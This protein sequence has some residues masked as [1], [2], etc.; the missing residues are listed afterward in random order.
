MSIPCPIFLPMGRQQPPPYENPD[1][2]VRILTLSGSGQSQT[3][4]GVNLS[5]PSDTGGKGFSWIKSRNIVGNHYFTPNYTTNNVGSINTPGALIVN[6]SG[7]KV[8]HVVNQ[9]SGANGGTTVLN[10]PNNGLAN[11]DY[12]MYT[13]R[14]DR[15]TNWFSTYHYQGLTAAF[16]MNPLLNAPPGLIIVKHFDPAGRGIWW[17]VWHKDFDNP[18]RDSLVLN[19]DIAMQAGD[20]WDNFAPTQS[21]WR[22]GGELRH[23]FN[24]YFAFIFGHDTSPTGRVACG[25]YTGNGSN[26]GPK[27]YCGWR[28]GWLLV[29]R[30]DSAGRW[31]MFDVSRPFQSNSNDAELNPNLDGA[32]IYDRNVARLMDG[33]APEDNDTDLNANGGEY[34]WMA[35]RLSDSY[36]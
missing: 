23:N 11:A 28:P 16:T 36:G 20:Y 17:R 35:L 32:E 34:V 29:K 7:E 22:V 13:I 12:V 10:N 3:T 26:N 33:W 8:A 4:N 24:Q 18:A 21:A 19:A 2:D 25:R 1:F 6:S 9:Y 31:M 5:V 27:Q 15:N 30:L 14:E